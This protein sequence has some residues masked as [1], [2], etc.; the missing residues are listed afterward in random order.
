MAA[1]LMAVEH[2]IEQCQA[3]CTQPNNL[4]LTLNLKVTG[5]R[6]D[7]Q[8]GIIIFTSSVIWSLDSQ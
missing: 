5:F 4:V 3:R 2:A 8:L 6:E 7:I 1:L